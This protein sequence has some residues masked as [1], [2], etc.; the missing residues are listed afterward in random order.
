[1][2]TAPAAAAALQTRF[3][4][5]LE[6]HRRLLYKVARLYGRSPADRDDLVQEIVV[7]LWRAFPRFDDHQK[8]STWIYR[9]ALNVAISW[10]RREQTRGR[11][12]V[13]AGDEVLQVAGGLAAADV[14]DPDLTLLY[15][16]IGQFDELDRALLMLYL[17]GH[18]HQEIGGVL[19]ITT[20]NAATRLSRLKERLRD[21]FRAAGRL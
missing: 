10:L 17:D 11:H 4:D 21:C 2:N 5:L 1:M 13:A 9:I 15:R 16:C 7:Q 8:A 3:L 20:T 12:L 18:S 19:G 6:A 14:V